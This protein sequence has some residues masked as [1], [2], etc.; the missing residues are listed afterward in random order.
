M[1]RTL[2]WNAKWGWPRDRRA[3]ECFFIVFFVVFVYSSVL[4]LCNCICWKCVYLI[5]PITLHR[6]CCEPGSMPANRLLVPQYGGELQL[7]ITKTPTSGRFV[8][9]DHGRLRDESNGDGELA[10]GMKWL[11]VEDWS[12]GKYCRSSTTDGEFPTVE[13]GI[14]FERAREQKS[15]FVLTSTFVTWLKLNKISYCFKIL[16]V[17]FVANQ[18]PLPIASRQRCSEHIRVR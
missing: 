11:R 8:Q 16:F 15:N 1:P 7:Y 10:T 2:P 13:N 12:T 4:L 18:Q 17:K 14:V 9:H 3:W 6:N 5:L